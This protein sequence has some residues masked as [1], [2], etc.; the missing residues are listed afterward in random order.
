[1]SRELLEQLGRTAVDDA[2]GAFEHD[3]LVQPLLV[4]PARLERRSRHAGR[5][6]R[7]AASSGRT[8]CR[9]ASSSP[10]RPSHARVTCGAPSASSVTTCAS[11]SESTIVR[12]SAGS[13]TVRTLHL[14]PRRRSRRRSAR[15]WS[16]RCPGSARARRA[17]AAAGAAMPWRCA[18]CSTTYAGTPSARARSRRHAFSASSSL[19]SAG[20][21]RQAVGRER[22]RRADRRARPARRTGSRPIHR[23]R[24]RSPPRRAAARRRCRSTRRRSAPFR[25]RRRSRARAPGRRAH[26][27]GRLGL[28]GGAGRAIS[29]RNRVRAGV[30]ATRCTA[31][32]PRVSATWKMRRSSST[33]SARWCGISPSWAPSTTTYGHSMPFTRCTV[34][35]V[36]S[37]GC[38]VD[39]RAVEHAAQP[40]LEAGRIGREPGD[41]DAAR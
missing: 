14:R 7:S 6:G 20:A 34:D 15:A 28:R 25:L 22:A 3:V 8:T 17:T 32:S 30:S 18:S 9:S 41:R 11:A 35:S 21:E 39:S 40:R 24:P 38:G 19:S 26:R 23:P 37:P 1:M 10:S 13:S 2:C 12:T 36:T 31:V 5:G 4:A 16:A 33:S 27:R 29:S